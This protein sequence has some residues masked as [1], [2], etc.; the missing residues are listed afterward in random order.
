VLEAAIQSSLDDAP[1]GVEQPLPPTQLKYGARQY[2]LVA[3]HSIRQGT[4]TVEA[5]AK[6][7]RWQGQ[8][9]SNAVAII[10]ESILDLET[11]QKSAACQVLD[12]LLTFIMRV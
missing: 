9:S 6:A 3:N 10:S 5:G 4:D 12:V 8:P 11:I 7:D 1:E 2:V